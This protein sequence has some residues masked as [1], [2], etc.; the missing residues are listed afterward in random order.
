MMQRP[1]RVLLTGSLPM[2]DHPAFPPGPPAQ[3]WHHPVAWALLH[4]SIK[5]NAL[6]TYQS[7]GGI[8]LI[9]VPSSQMALVYVKLTK[10]NS[11]QNTQTQ[12]NK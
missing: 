10:T 4:Q 7:D 11:P 6:Q 12:T 3:G 1:Q 2:P 5:K 8:V 9:D